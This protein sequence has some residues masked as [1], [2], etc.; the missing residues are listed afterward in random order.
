VTSNPFVCRSLG[1]QALPFADSAFDILTSNA[2]LERVG[3]L[4]NQRSFLR[5]LLRVGK[6]IFV[7]VPNRLFP[8]EHHT[9]IP[10]LSNYCLQRRGK[11]RR[12]GII[13]QLKP[14][15]YV[16]SAVMREGDGIRSPVSRIQSL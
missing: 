6:K 13:V 2:A 1:G 9:A 8:V 5:E 12:G 3:S 16:H 14:P 10:L 7:T 11:A 4:E 15:P